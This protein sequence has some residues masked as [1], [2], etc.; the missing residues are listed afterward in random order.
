MNVYA[1]ISPRFRLLCCMPNSCFDLFSDAVGASS[2]HNGVSEHEHMCDEIC[3]R[4][5]HDKAM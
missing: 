3:D 1:P 5:V 4:N 2:L